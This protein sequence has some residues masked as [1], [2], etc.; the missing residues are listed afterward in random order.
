[1]CEGM[2]FFFLGW[3]LLVGA[4]GLKGNNAKAQTE[5]KVGPKKKMKDRQQLAHTKKASE[6]D[7]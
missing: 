6:T 1:M 4:V 7:E 3:V 5:S 2:D